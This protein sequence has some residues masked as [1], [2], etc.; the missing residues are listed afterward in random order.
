M[1]KKQQNIKQVLFFAAVLLALIAATAA[2]IVAGRKTTTDDVGAKTPHGLFAAVYYEAPDID[3]NGVHDAGEEW[4]VIEE[5]AIN[6][7]G[8]VPGQTKFYRIKIITYEESILFTMDFKDISTTIAPGSTATAADV[9]SRLYITLRVEDINGNPIAG[10]SPVSSD[11]L[12]YLGGD[13]VTTKAVYSIDLT[14]YEE[15]EVNIYYYLGLTPGH[16]EGFDD[17]LLL[18]GAAFDIGQISLNATD[19]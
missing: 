17:D 19:A 7:S 8:L 13:S 6:Y 5:K 16:V 4:Q 11:L 15:S 14:G 2:W 3:K 18:S 12:A 10:A 1:T 9:L